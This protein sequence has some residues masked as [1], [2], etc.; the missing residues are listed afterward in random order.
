MS[1]QSKP[2][3]SMRSEPVE[4]TSQF[5]QYEPGHVFPAPEYELLSRSQD[6]DS[7]K[8]ATKERQ[9]CCSRSPAW[10]LEI[11][12]IAASVGC[13][14]GVVV[15]LAQMKDRPLAE[16]TVVLNLNSSIAVLIT[17]LKSTAMLAVA[18]CISQNKW[19]FFKRRRARLQQ[20]DTFDEA[21]R[22]P[23]ALAGCCGRCGAGSIS[24]SSGP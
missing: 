14:I 11:L 16:W 15:I 12:A 24:R 1:P 6:G 7:V 18:S 8:A 9:R 22:G 10:L 21:S 3:M 5:Q 23:S 20:L 17:A 19:Q 4:Y 13:M 2:Q